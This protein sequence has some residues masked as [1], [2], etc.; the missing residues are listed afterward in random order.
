MENATLDRERE[1][2]EKLRDAKERKARAEAEFELA[3]ETLYKVENELI[4]LLDDQG[5]KST[6]KY[7]GLGYVTIPKGRIYASF[8]EGQEEIA[9]LEI[10]RSFG[11]GDMIK[12][13]VHVASLSSFVKE[14][15]EKN[16][17]L[18]KGVTFYERRGTMFIPD[19]KSNN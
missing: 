6:A 12:R 10:D 1:L 18:P 8:I 5:K 7:E 17:P 19:K 14:L 9:L 16:S 13:T 15:I 3:K 2:V 4:E 11:R